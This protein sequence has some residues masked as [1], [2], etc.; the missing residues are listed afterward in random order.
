[1]AREILGQITETIDDGGG[2]VVTR[3]IGSVVRATPKTGGDTFVRLQIRNE[4]TWLFGG[5][6]LTFDFETEDIDPA[7]GNWNAE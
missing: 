3:K 6:P 5:D 1:M 2:N 7:T 4:G